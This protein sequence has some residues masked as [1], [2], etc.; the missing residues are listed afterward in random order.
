M[1]VINK[2]SILRGRL[3]HTWLENQV[4]NKTVE[5]VIFLWRL[6]KWRALKEEF[7]F[8]VQETLHLAD[9]MVAGFSPAQLVETLAPLHALSPETKKHL[10]EAVH[11]AYLECSGIQEM[12][13]NLNRTATVVESE[14]KRLIAIWHK[15]PTPENELALRAGWHSLSEKADDLLAVLSQ[16]PKGIVLP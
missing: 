13:L 7:G 5:D 11:N 4:C 8:R 14:L 15:P 16:L 1:N 12:A 9:E 10:K 2:A 3:K 6:G